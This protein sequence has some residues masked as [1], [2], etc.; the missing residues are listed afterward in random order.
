[1]NYMAWVH[2]IN[3]NVPFVHIFCDQ[4]NIKVSSSALRSF[5]KIKGFDISKWI[6]K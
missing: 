1:M 6:V 3:M 2:E 5:T 4:E